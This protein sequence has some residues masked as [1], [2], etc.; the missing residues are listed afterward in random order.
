VRALILAGGKGSRLRPFTFTIPKPL[1]PIG[2]MSVLEILIRQLKGQ[3]FERITI[4]VGHLAGL[5]RAF[6]GDGS[7][8]G[9]PIDYVY[10]D[11]PL[12]T[13]GCLA[14]LDLQEADRMPADRMPADRILVINGDTLT[15]MSMAEAY[16][17]HD[18]ADAITICANRRSVGIDFGVLETDGEGYLSTYTEKPTLHYR[19]SMGVNVVSAWA[20]GAYISR[21][22]RLDLP[23]LVEKLL[24]AGQRV[25]VREVEAYWLDLGR[26]QDLEEGER[27]FRAN[28]QRFLP[29]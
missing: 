28:P 19:V 25:R 23:G 10:E 9:I 14:L 29:E 5:I 2:D 20:V 21:G 18:G 12:G 1:V 27:V 15:D 7:Q 8:W 22:E 13:I 11:Q 6:C 26:M 16:A 3:G 24:A 4:S 17:A